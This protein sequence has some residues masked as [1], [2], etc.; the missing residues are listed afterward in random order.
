MSL[1]YKMV[2]YATQMVQAPD[3]YIFKSQLMMNMPL[4]IATFKVEP[5]LSR[6]GLGV[7]T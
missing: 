4:A 1:Y 2:Q 5:Q 3:R 7:I 6:L